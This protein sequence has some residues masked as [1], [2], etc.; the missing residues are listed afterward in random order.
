MNTSLK[1]TKDRKVTN[2]P[3]PNGKIATIANSFSLPAGGDYS[4]QD[5]TEYCEKI[6]YAGKLEKIFKGFRENVTHN[7]NILVGMSEDEMVWTLAKVVSDFHK[8][9]VK[10]IDKGEDIQPIFRIH[11]D[12]DFFSEEYMNA[13]VRVIEM[14]D[15]VTFWVYT[16]SVMSAVRLHKRNLENLSLYFSSDPDNIAL[17]VMLNTTYGIRIAHVDET[18]DSGRD[19]LE[20][21]GITSVKCPENT[22]ALPLISSKGSAC[23]VC[24][25]CVFG[26][27]N[28]RF[29]RTKK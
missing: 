18:F 28:V 16:R 15:D 9:T 14:F 1:A 19:I 13:W 20:K 4:C 24:G 27:R 7:W 17:A 10:W 3:S 22:G 29:S 5:S 12:G 8:I 11:A 21:N 2:R 25:L 6:C 26:R 23:A